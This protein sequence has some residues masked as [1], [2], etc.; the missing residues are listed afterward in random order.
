MS[1]NA[2]LFEFEESFEIDSAMLEEAKVELELVRDFVNNEEFN[3]VL[4]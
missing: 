2:K 3:E 4:L 1:N